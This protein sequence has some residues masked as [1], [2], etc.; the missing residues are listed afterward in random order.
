MRDSHKTS[1]LVRLGGAGH[2]AFLSCAYDV[3][4]DWRKPTEL[5]ASYA[6]ILRSKASPELT[7]LALRL[8][9]RDSK[10]ALLEDSL[11][12]GTTALEFVLQMMRVREIFDRK[13][14]INR[15]GTSLQIIDDVIDWENDVTQGDNNCLT[16]KTLRETYLRRLEEDFDTSTCQKLFPYGVVLGL[17]IKQTQ[18]KAAN[19]LAF[20]EKYF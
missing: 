3:V 20:P 17:V 15:L 5:Q 2:A 9:D 14:D 6:Q 11:E 4:T 18:Q 10:G 1:L 16:N 8:L 13:C 7:N 12:R 19:M